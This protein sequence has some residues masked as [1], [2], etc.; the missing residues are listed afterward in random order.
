M[1]TY[2]RGVDKEGGKRKRTEKIFFKCTL[3]TKYIKV[4]NGLSADPVFKTGVAKIQQDIVYR[5]TM[6][7]TE[8]FAFKCL[9]NDNLNTNESDSDDYEDEYDFAKAVVV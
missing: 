8:N 1:S 6:T 2:F 7:V 9:L 5:V 3:G 4:D